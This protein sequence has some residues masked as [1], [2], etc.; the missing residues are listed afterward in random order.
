[1]S[2]TELRQRLADEPEVHEPN[3]ETPTNHPFL[4]K[5]WKPRTKLLFVSL[6]LLT[7]PLTMFCLFYFKF[8]I[9]AYI[10]GLVALILVNIIVWVFVVNVLLEEREWKNYLARKDMIE[11]EN[12]GLSSDDDLDMGISEQLA[13]LDDS[14]SN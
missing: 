6:L 12:R 3:I 9:N 1:M 11:K 4:K 5:R 7:V 14:D 13:R 2:D 8:G 10:A